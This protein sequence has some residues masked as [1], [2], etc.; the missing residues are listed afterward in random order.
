MLA[1]L[2]APLL[3]QSQSPDLFDSF[4]AGIILLQMAVPQ[5][6]GTGGLKRVNP[7]LKSLDNDVEA[8]RARCTSR[9]LMF[10]V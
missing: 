5:L 3:W 8:W 10:R 2:A 1:L 6:R 9:F 4:T 7:E